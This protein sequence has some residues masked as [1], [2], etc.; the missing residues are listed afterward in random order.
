MPLV[1]ATDWLPAV[2]AAVAGGHAELVTLMGVD[3]DGPEVW[4]RLRH[5]VEDDLVL[6]VAATEVD[7]IIT[8]LPQAAWYEREAA[9]MYGIGFR[10][11][12]TRPLLLGA[13]ATPPMR[14]AVFLES[15]Q[16]AP[17]PGEKE[18]GGVVARR[19]QV[20]PGVRS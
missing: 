19:R 12:D 4:L 3:V 1:E 20:P 9:E 8:L 2:R 5:P 14:R 6:R 15:R 16:S 18:P 17:W 10:G 11:H 7:S 13:D